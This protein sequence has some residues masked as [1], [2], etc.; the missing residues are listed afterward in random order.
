ML[1]IPIRQS[2]AQFL[3]IFGGEHRTNI[4]IARDVS[5]TVRYG[6]EPSH[7]YEIRDLPQ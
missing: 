1:W 3:D 4:H 5:R 2:F 6:G 7:D